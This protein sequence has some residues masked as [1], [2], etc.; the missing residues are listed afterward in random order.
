M[1]VSASRSGASRSA[2]VASLRPLR[3][4][5]P[6]QLSA[7]A[8]GKGFGS[9]K[10]ASSLEAELVANVEGTDG[11]QQGLAVSSVEK[12]A[13]GS[14]ESV[15]VSGPANAKAP[16]AAQMDAAAD[17]SASAVAH[18]DGACTRSHA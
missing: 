4:A 13:D 9:K 15:T 18:L 6:L 16:S 17:A 2:R 12:G 1:A 10:S 5:R 7:G 14:I 8:G 11:Q 3:R